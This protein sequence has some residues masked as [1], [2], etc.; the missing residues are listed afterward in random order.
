VTNIIN[1]TI[2]PLSIIRFSIAIELQSIHN[3]SSIELLLNHFRLLL[4]YNQTSIE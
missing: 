1:I 2:E 4:N 3:R